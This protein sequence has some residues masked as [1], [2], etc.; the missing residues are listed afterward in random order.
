[1]IGALVQQSAGAAIGVFVGVLIGL[2]IRKRRGKSE[3]LLGG[4]VF[5]TA[6]AA[7]GAALIAM[8]AVTYF[9]HGS[10]S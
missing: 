1:M 7:G 10:G 6:S 9:T 3:G 5:L 4:S 8:M 2:S